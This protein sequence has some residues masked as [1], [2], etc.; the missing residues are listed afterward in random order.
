M[1]CV[2]KHH[3]SIAL[4]HIVKDIGKCKNKSIKVN[5]NQTM[6]HRDVV[7]CAAVS[8]INTLY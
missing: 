4:K 5:R 1:V 8:S 7:E 3:G 2:R 6:Y